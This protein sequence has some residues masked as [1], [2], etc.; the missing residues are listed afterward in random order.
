MACHW[1]WLV[2]EDSDAWY[3]AGGGQIRNAAGTG[4]DPDPFLGQ[5]VDLKLSYGFW[6]GRFKV[7]GGCSHFFNGDYLDAFGKGEDAD[8]VYVMT[9]LKF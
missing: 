4:L 9:V 1:L 3:N 6:N 5:E 7:E 2:E 8:F